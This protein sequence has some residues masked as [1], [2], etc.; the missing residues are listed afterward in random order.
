MTS[1]SVSLD[2]TPSLQEV[3]APSLFSVSGKHALV[4]GATRG[5]GASVAL[6]LAQGGASCCLVVRPG[7]S[8]NARHPALE[9]L[10]QNVAPGQ[11]HSVVEADL[12]DNTQVKA[13]FEKALQQM[14]NRID[15]LINC[16][17]IQRRKPATDF[18]EE[19]WDEVCS[20]CKL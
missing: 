7:N 2:S 20:R 5:I 3:Q 1:T 14:D 9:P 13:V 17:G 16:G 4:T 18:L 6:A 19:D 11:K 15:I 8:N 12:A 10:P